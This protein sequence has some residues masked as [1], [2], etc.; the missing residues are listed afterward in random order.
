MNVQIPLTALPPD[1]ANRIEWVHGNFLR[2]RFPFEDEEF[3]HVHIG[4]VAFG[5]PENK[6]PSLYEEIR[7]VMRTD[8]TIE[9]I[10]EGARCLRT[11]GS[12]SIPFL[13]FIWQM[14]SSLSFRGGLRSLYIR[15]RVDRTPTSP[16]AH[17]F[18]P[19]H[20]VD[21]LA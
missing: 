1:I 21:H 15:T 19:T 11:A 3:D 12:P 2:T 5:V 6:W 4:G 10:E 14:P 9:Q 20:Q 18:R 16:T 8:G 17:I 13:S 7:R